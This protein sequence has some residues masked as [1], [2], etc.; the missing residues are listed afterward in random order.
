[1]KTQLLAL[2]LCALCT[3]AASR[4]ADSNGF[5]AGVPVASDGAQPLTIPAAADRSGR[6][7]ARVLVNGRGPYRFMVDT[8]ANHTALAASLLPELGISVDK[9]KSMTVLGIN[10][11]VTAPSV[12]LDSL[13]VGGLHM[14]D[15]QVPVLAGPLLADIDGI[16][17]IDGLEN[18]TMTANFLHDRFVVTGSLGGVPIGDVLVPGR[19]ISQHLLEVD[20]R[21]NG[22]KAKA[23]IDT[24][25]PRTLANWALLKALVRKSGASASS[26]PTNIIDATEA[27]Q[28]AIIEPVASMK[29]GAAT[30]SGNL[31]LIFGSFRV[32]K[33]W[34]LEDQPAVLVGMDVLGSFAEITIDYRRKE[35]GLYP[36][37]DMINI[38]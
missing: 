21:V 19:L 30:T 2:A 5:A 6:I 24:G 26:L 34:G 28:A 25:S 9:D 20:C 23:V 38:K 35:L 17:G 16:L 4:D 18:R 14:G 32:F 10:G 15:M 29:I 22:V 31:Y 1:M 33:T 11:S 13:D 12:H 3:S 37:P 36:R 8:G 27:L 7:L